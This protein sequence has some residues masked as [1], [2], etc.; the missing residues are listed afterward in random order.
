[1][2]REN[3]ESSQSQSSRSARHFRVALFFVLLTTL[4]VLSMAQCI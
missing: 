1:M 4:P 2:T 3:P